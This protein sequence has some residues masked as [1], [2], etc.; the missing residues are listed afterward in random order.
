VERCFIMF[1]IVPEAFQ[2]QCGL[3]VVLERCF[4]AL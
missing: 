4:S 1:Y 3:E 2:G